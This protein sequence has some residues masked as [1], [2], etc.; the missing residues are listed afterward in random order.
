MLQLGF[1][2]GDLTP[3]TGMEM[4]GGFFK[5]AGKAGRD[6]LLAV[7]CVVHDGTTPVALV[8]IDTLFI[9]RPTVEQARRAIQAATQIPGDHFLIGASHTH[10]GGPIASCLGCDANPAYLDKV[11]KAITGA[12]DGAWHTLHAAELGIGTG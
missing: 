4:P 7:A 1:G 9:T 2:T 8:G 10:S 3:E 12:V 11:V 6:K 5:R